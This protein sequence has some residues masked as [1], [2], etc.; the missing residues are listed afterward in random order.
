MKSQEPLSDPSQEAYSGPVVGALPSGRAPTI[1]TENLSPRE[2]D[3]STRQEVGDPGQGPELHRDPD[4]APSTSEKYPVA[5]SATSQDIQS[6]N[7]GGQNSPSLNRVDHRLQHGLPE[8]PLHTP[9]DNSA[10][11]ASL[12]P[13]PASTNPQIKMP[14]FREILALKDPQERIQAYNQTREQ[15]ANLNTGLSHWLVVTTNKLP[16]H[17][18]LVASSGLIAPK[19]QGHRP[20][21]SRSKLAGFLPSGGQSSSQVSSQQSPG[22]NAQN[23]TMFGSGGAGGPSQGFSPGASGGKLS[24]QQVQ[25]KG[26]DFLRSAGVVGGKANVAAKGLFSKGKSKLRAASGNEKV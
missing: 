16:E 26:K 19:T 14:A 10:H 9:T 18:D 24:S 25:A 22:A 7:L 2:A 4:L 3:G 21:P 23:G 13:A 8:L 12:P 1:D 15:F 20:S 5:P 17:A 6:G 11:E